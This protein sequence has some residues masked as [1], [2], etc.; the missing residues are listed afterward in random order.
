L[1]WPAAAPAAV[2]SPVV[3]VDVVETAVWM[4]TEAKRP[5]EDAEQEW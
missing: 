1:I 4:A 5:Q 2:E 3:D